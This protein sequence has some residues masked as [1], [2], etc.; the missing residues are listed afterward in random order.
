M[1]LFSQLASLP[2]FGDGVGLHRVAWFAEDYKTQ[3]WFQQ[4]DAIKVTGSNGKGSV[5]AMLAAIFQALGITQGR[6]TSPHLLKFNERFNLN[7]H[8]ASDNDL[9]PSLAWL[10]TKLAAYERAFPA[11]TVG[12]FE[13]FTALAL[14]YYAHHAPEALITE[15]GIGGRYDSTRVFPGQWVGLA[16]LDLEHTAL[17]G[18]RLELIAYDK[19]DL[20]PEGGTLVVG[21]LEAEV[22]RRLRAYCE[23]RHVRLIET[24]L[25]S[26]FENLRYTATTMTL[27]L[28]VEDLI[29]R[30]LEIGLQG[31]HQINNAVVAIVLA[32]RWLQTHRVYLS[33]AD[34]QVGVA[35]GLAAVTWPGRFQKIQSA[36]DIYMDVGHTP[37]AI[38]CL[39]ATTREALG[40]QP[41]VLVTG[42]SKDKEV[43]GIVTRL[44]SLA[45]VVVCAR[46]YH[47]G[48][49]AANIAEVVERHA[50]HLPRYVEERIEDALAV[51]QG[52]ARAN[53]QAVLVA[54]GLFLA[55]EAWEVLRGGRP[56]ALMFF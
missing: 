1:D 48:S 19:A 25:F 17:L 44:L 53:G 56:E 7:Q 43:E 46:A 23:L 35:R 27:D 28:R 3:P 18:H 24:T 5:C 32:R 6:Y 9:A 33:T 38:D 55:I 14:H 30:E 39:V 52:L 50:P 20:C 31:R 15:V 12:A 36:P 22:L 10:Q 13:A 49:P 2:K 34:F 41:L 29:W 8:D 42:V 37:D 21:P 11:D 40:E 45:S 16:S 47:K 51:A 4:L 54:G 26:H